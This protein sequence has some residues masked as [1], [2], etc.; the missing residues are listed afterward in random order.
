MGD[1]SHMQC[2]LPLAKVRSAFF[3]GGQIPTYEA[4]R[5]DGIE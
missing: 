3:T 2:I 1:A 4:Y 5:L